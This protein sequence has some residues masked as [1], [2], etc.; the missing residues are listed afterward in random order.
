MFPF[1]KVNNHVLERLLLLVE[2]QP[3]RLNFF[4]KCFE[5]FLVVGIRVI[6][7]NEV[8]TLLEGQPEYFAAQNQYQSSP[9]SRGVNSV[10]ADSV[11]REQPFLFIK[12]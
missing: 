2:L 6:H 9:V 1:I 5:L 3:T 4:D 12:A 7:G 11:G 10:L 8:G